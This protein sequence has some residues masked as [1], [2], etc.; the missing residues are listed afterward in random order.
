MIARSLAHASV[1]D[2]GW[3]VRGVDAKEKGYQ[4]ESLLYLDAILEAS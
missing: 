4:D 1:L 2:G 3:Q